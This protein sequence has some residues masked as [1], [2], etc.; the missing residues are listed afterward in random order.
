MPTYCGSLSVEPK[1]YVQIYI[2]PRQLQVAAGR[3][4][5]QLA[6]SMHVGILLQEY[7]RYITRFT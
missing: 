6:G 4:P 5:L 7:T 1:T 3:L 2:E